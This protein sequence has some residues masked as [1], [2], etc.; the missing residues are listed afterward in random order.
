MTFQRNEYI[1]T[2]VQG[3]GYAGLDGNFGSK[4]ESKEVRLLGKGYRSE[5]KGRYVENVL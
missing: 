1:L 5:V 2:G 4:L 3:I